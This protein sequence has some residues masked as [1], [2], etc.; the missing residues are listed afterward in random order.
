[1]SNGNA[2][3]PWFGGGYSSPPLPDKRPAL[4]PEPG[5]QGPQDGAGVKRKRWRTL[6]AL[7]VVIL[8]I[9]GAFV[10]VVWAGGPRPVG[11]TAI[12]T[13]DS[14]HG[15]V[16]PATAQQG[17]HLTYASGANAYRI[18]GLSAGD[19]FTSTIVFTNSGDVTERLTRVATSARRTIS[20]ITPA[21][22][23]L[24]PAPASARGTGSPTITLAPGASTTA[25]LTWKVRDCP[26]AS[27]TATVT[28][29]V[30]VAYTYAHGGGWLKSTLPFG[31]QL[32]NAPSCAP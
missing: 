9:V 4:P 22:V 16:F 2:N 30:S 8:L 21:F 28:P 18:T 25:F 19:S 7:V 14:E 31:L 15:V 11:R 27:S 29:T 3:V 24:V 23:S 6:I 20:G 1:M 10:L 12:V 13:M 32:V 26:S 5:L 17:W